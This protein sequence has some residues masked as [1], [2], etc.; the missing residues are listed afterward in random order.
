MGIREA[1]TADV[2]VCHVDEAVWYRT[3]YGQ[4]SR[5]VRRRVDLRIVLRDR[6]TRAIARSWNSSGR[7]GREQPDPVHHGTAQY[8]RYPAGGSRDLRVP[9]RV[10]GSG[11]SRSAILRRVRDGGG[12][13][14]DGEER[15][16][17]PGDRGD[18]SDGRFF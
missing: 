18:G 5:G 2:A 10:E 12:R 3:A 13:G 6:A 15:G 11:P 1:A 7:D 16:R 4:A 14:D 8:D 9:V 17:N